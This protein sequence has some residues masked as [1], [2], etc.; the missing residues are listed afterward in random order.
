MWSIHLDKKQHK[1]LSDEI[2][3]QLQLNG[4]NKQES[5]AHPFISRGY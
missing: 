3:S 1:L 5:A 4:I 2:L